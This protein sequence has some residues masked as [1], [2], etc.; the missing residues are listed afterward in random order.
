MSSARLSELHREF[1]Q[2]AEAERGVLGAM[3]LSPIDVRAMCAEEGVGTAEFYLPA[4]AALFKAMAG[5]LDAGRPLEFIVLL[6]HLQ[7]AGQLDTVGGPAYL[8]ELS[9]LLPSAAYV[10]HHIEI[11]R[12]KAKRRALIAALTRA[13][14]TAY[15]GAD[16]TQELISDTHAA[17][18][19]L[20]HER[21]KRPAV[22]DVV[23]EIIAEVRDGR[24]DTGLIAMNLPGIGD[25]L[26]L[27][28]GDLLIISAPTSCGKT[29]LASQ[30]ALQLAK[31]GRRVAMYPL[32]MAQRQ[33]LRRAIAQIGGHNAD[34]VRKL[35][36][37][38]DPMN[39]SQKTR[40]IVGEFVETAKAVIRFGLHIRDDL[41]RWDQIRADL[42]TEHAK[43]P[44][45]F[46]MIDYLQLIQTGTRHERK[47]LAIAEITQ[48]AKM[49]AKEL[50]C[51][52]CIPSQVN[53][54]GGTREAQDAENDASALV[55]IHGEED[56]SGDVHPGRVSIWKQR[57]GQRHVDLPL[58]FNGLLTRFE[59]KE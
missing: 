40:Q 14:T 50:D 17:V 8:N 23:N 6:Q 24:D 43:R 39:P 45:A 32:E 36:R 16:D 22:V 31:E 47:Q 7:D 54:E 27:Y 35:V 52:I 44:F 25:R 33:M 12:E 48:G 21:S 15:D 51:I 11:V 26:R 30:I 29:A 1:P 20:V 18:G 56:A 4:H 34:F 38:A 41:F 42:R 5:I 59:E 2:S 10:K 3:F 58:Q 49:L 9:V 37:Q 19:A 57:E 55:K 28:R 13:L 53:K 46:A